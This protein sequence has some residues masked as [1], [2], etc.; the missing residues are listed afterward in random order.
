MGALLVVIM[1]CPTEGM[2]DKGEEKEE[3]ERQGERM[4]IER[5]QEPAPPDGA[6]GV[7]IVLMEAG[8]L[9]HL[10]VRLR[11]F[12]FRGAALNEKDRQEDVGPHLQK[13]A[14]PVFQ[15][16]GPEVAT[17]EVRRVP[18]GGWWCACWSAL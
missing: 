7:R 18:E 10:F 5:Q 2:A 8:V 6:R 1:G 13:L 9:V 17:P 12:G 15:H 16:R 11:V 3:Q 14:L 4:L